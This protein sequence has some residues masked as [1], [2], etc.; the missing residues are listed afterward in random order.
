MF[1]AELNVNALL[2]SDLYTCITNVTYL[3]VHVYLI[4]TKQTD[5]KTPGGHV[6]SHERF[7]DRCRHHS[8]RFFFSTT[9]DPWP[10]SGCARAA[11]VAVSRSVPVSPV[12]ECV[13]A[14]LSASLLSVTGSPFPLSSVLEWDKGLLS[15]LGDPVGVDTAPLD[16]ISPELTS[17]AR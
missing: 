7:D 1:Y 3:L 10:G 2:Y 8:G 15:V 9:R 11:S 16:W 14:G 4:V 17:D 12:P 13:I 5:S 6:K